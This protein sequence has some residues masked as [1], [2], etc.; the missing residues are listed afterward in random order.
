MAITRVL[1][2]S[3]SLR[4]ASWNSRLVQ[5]AL[6]GA[7]SAGAETTYIALRDYS[8][9][10]YDQEIEDRDGLPEN[11]RKLKELF[12]SHSGLLIAC[13]EYNSSITAALKNVIDW[14]SR[15]LP[16]EK[17][18][19]CFTGKICGLLAASP[20]ALGG[21]RGLV[22][23]RSILSN[24][25]VIV[26]PEQFALQKAHEAFGDDGRLKD[27]AQQKTAAGIAEKVARIAAKLA[28]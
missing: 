9:P 28:G 20:G 23:V 19:E 8:L 12:K 1:A 4:A 14:V 22:T 21:L 7:Q 10:V 3:G 15:P 16:T 18:L 5:A 11:A 26:L 27:P 2:F 24:I 25:G 6:T 13:P 17:P